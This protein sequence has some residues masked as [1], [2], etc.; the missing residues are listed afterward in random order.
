M[1]QEKKVIIISRGR[2]FEYD[3]FYTTLHLKDLCLIFQNDESH[4]RF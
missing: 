2:S 4:L 1:T 3:I